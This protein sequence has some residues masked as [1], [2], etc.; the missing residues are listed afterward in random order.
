[1]PERW[2][3]ADFDA[4]GNYRFERVF[5]VHD[6][7]LYTEKYAF[8]FC[9]FDNIGKSFLFLFQTVTTIN[10]SYLMY[11]VMDSNVAPFAAIYC[12]SLIFIGTFTF[13]QLIIATLKKNIADELDKLL[14]APVEGN[15][16]KFEEVQKSEWSVGH[17][18]LCIAGVIKEEVIPVEAEISSES[19]FFNS[20]AM[21]IK[22]L[23]D[24]MLAV[25]ESSAYERV[26]T[27]LILINTIALAILHYPSSEK[28]NNTVDALNYLLTLCFSVD[29]SLKLIAYGPVAYC[30]DSS[31]L[32]DGFIVL[33]SI[34]DLVMSPVPYLFSHRHIVSQGSLSALRTFRLFRLFRIFNSGPLKLLFAKLYR[35]ALSMREFL[36]L[37]M[38]YLFVFTLIGMQFFANRMRFDANGFLITDFGSEEWLHPDEYS[39]YNFDDFNHA[40]ATVFQVMALD[41]WFVVLYNCGRANGNVGLLFP[42][43]CYLLGYVVLFNMFLAMLIDGFMRESKLSSDEGKTIM[44]TVT[45]NSDEHRTAA[46]NNDGEGLK[47]VDEDGSWRCLCAWN[48]KVYSFTISSQAE[49]SEDYRRN[50]EEDFGYPM[51]SFDGDVEATLDSIARAKISLELVWLRH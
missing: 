40:V 12:S 35:C 10:W 27:L 50:D 45:K 29:C 9:N 6:F 33:V 46:R 42:I 24:R 4:W 38:I 28:L 2:C 14:G 19:I 34:I 47:G 37:L 5:P 22:R 11:S 16:S 26:V 17:S 32:F 36:V 3:G 25:V 41:G 20:C 8:G 48:S 13:M 21:R 30:S 44:N 23:Q 49:Q 51:D 18:C 31:H 39:R 43:A 15:D 7:T 1:M